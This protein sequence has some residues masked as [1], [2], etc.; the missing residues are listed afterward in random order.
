MGDPAILQAATAEIVD[1][2]DATCLLSPKS[3]VLDLGCGI[4][5]VAAALAPRCSTVLGVDVST[6]MVDEARRRHAALGNVAFVVG[7]G[8]DVPP[9]PFDLVLL[10]DSMPYIV[11]AGL[12]DEIVDRC[13]AAMRP[14]ATLVVLNLSY[15]RDPAADRADALHWASTHGWLL[16]VDRPFTLWDGS[17]FVFRSSK[18]RQNPCSIATRST[19]PTR[20][21]RTDN[22]PVV[23]TCRC[24]RPT[25]NLR[26]RMAVSLT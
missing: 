22:V 5:R 26:R 23:T 13:A 7:N 24:F 17:A 6:G 19:L 10:I 21:L 2:L 14:G 11:A 15:G 1:W 20:R 12:A 3:A 25:L 16:T 18:A 9:G 8:K 4:G